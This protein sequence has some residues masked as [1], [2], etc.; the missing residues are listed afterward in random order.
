MGN[1]EISTHGSAELWFVVGGACRASLA[2]NALQWSC[3]YSQDIANLVEGL[4]EK[5]A[6]YTHTLSDSQN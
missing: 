2:I 6:Q 3:G 5:Q 1:G 4:L